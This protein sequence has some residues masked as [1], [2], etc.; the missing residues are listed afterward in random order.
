MPYK[1]YNNKKDK[2]YKYIL[3]QRKRR[4]KKNIE[5]VVQG[6]KGGRL[7][8]RAKNL[9]RRYGGNKPVKY[10]TKSRYFRNFK[11]DLS[12]SPR[13]S[14]LRRNIN[15]ARRKA[16][17]Y[18]P[19]KQSGI[20]IRDSYSSRRKDFIRIQNAKKRLTDRYNRRKAIP[21]YKKLRRG[22]KR[23]PYKQSK[24]YISTISK[25]YWTYDGLKYEHPSFSY[26]PAGAINV[27]DSYRAF[28]ERKRYLNR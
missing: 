6:W 16:Q 26:R 14:R 7:P 28:A 27:T 18:S 20:K 21:A 11:I 5:T 9:I 22:I 15:N 3:Y 24:G 19:E 1:R 13:S 23:L 8:N 4:Y 2:K 10:N 17:F 25:P 12:D